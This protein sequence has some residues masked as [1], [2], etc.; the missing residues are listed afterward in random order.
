MMKRNVSFSDNIEIFYI[1]SRHETVHPKESHL[2][3]FVSAQDE[4]SCHLSVFS[5]LLLLPVMYCLSLI[6]K[7][8]QKTNDE[9]DNIFRCAKDTIHQT[10]KMVRSCSIRIAFSDPGLD[11]ALKQA[12]VH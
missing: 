7:E 5:I 6:V 8:E 3:E 12:P 10:I 11:G 2:E 9:L 4:G 1:P